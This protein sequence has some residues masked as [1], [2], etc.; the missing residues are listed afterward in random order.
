MKNSGKMMENIKFPEKYR[1]EINDIFL[2]DLDANY[3]HHVFDIVHAHSVC[4]D[5][6]GFDK[7]YPLEESLSDVI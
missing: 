6:E 1:D 2:R 5:K 4:K 3:D 7:G